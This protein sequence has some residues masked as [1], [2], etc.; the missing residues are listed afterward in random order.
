M[1]PKITPDGKATL[2]LHVTNLNIKPRGE[3]ITNIPQIM[4]HTAQHLS[5]NNNNEPRNTTS[6]TRIVGSLPCVFLQ[7]IQWGENRATLFAI[8]LI[9]VPT[10][11]L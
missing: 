8:A 11:L 1:R 5:R 2:N 6:T 9:M 3:S 4:P 7:S 10:G